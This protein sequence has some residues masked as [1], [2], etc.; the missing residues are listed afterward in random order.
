VGNV[1]GKFA[2]INLFGGQV[3]TTEIMQQGISERDKL[4]EHLYTNA[5]GLG[6]SDP[7]F[8]ICG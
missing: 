3:F 7:C 5:A 2:N 8:F 6:D 1:R 4:E